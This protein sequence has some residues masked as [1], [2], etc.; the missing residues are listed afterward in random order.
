MDNKDIIKIKNERDFQNGMNEISKSKYLASKKATDENIASIEA[1]REQQEL[2]KIFKSAAKK[3]VVTNKSKNRILNN[4]AFRKD[5]STIFKKFTSSQNIEYSKFIT[6]RYNTVSYSFRKKGASSLEALKSSIFHSTRFVQNLTLEWLP[7][8]SK[9][10]HYYVDG[11]YMSHQEF[12]SNHRDQV[13]ADFDK[14]ISIGNN[15]A[16]INHRSDLATASRYRS[17]YFSKLKKILPDNHRSKTQFTTQISKWETPENKLVD[18]TSASLKPQVAKFRE[19]LKTQFITMGLSKK[20]IEN[21]FKIFDNYQCHRRK[22]IS[23]KKTSSN[24]QVITRNACAI[25]ESV[26]KIPHCNGVVITGESKKEML[27]AGVEFYKKHF[28]D[29]DIMFATY[30]ADEGKSQDLE[31]GANCHFFIKASSNNPAQKRTFSQQYLE[32]AKQQAIHLYPDIF[33]ELLNIDSSKKQPPQVMVCCGQITQLSML[34]HLQ[35]TFFNRKKIALR[36]LSTSE[37]REFSNI[38]AML[39]ESLPIHLRQQSRFHMLQD[40]SN[41]LSQNIALQSEK[42]EEIKKAT[43]QQ[44]KMLEAIDIWKLQPTPH[45]A[46]LTL[47]QLEMIDELPDSVKMALVEEIKSFEQLNSIDSEAKLSNKISKP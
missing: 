13:L 46:S 4:F 42:L 10:N 39:E 28:P 26:L 24:R 47:F 9:N 22:H 45:S 27:K 34:I 2:D 40:K 29:N 17:S 15:K 21:K 6:M 3:S 41:E 1:T 14:I 18:L 7:E 36:I 23:L 25:L 16:D 8:L 33:P 5:L 30:H 38:Q 12:Q 20:H 19:T 37:R 11:M 44:Q 35:K 31:T 43:V 32:M